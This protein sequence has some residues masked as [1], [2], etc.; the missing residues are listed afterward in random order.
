MG[1]MVSVIQSACLLGMDASTIKVEV[2][3]GLGMPGFTIVGLP[4][5]AVNESRE[6]VRAAIK[7][8][9]FDFPARKIVANLSPADVKKEGTLLDLPLALGVLLSTGNVTYTDWLS[10]SLWVGELSL[11]GS[12]N[13]VPGV[14]SIAMMAKQQGLHTV[15]VPR[16]NAEEAALVDGLQV[17]GLSHLSELPTALLNPATYHHCVDLTALYAQASHNSVKGVGVDF[18]HVKGHTV[19]KRALE[20][21]AAGG[22]NVM[23]FGPPGSGKSML[24]KAF[25]SI[26]PPMTP[27]EMLDVSRLYS[28]A[29]L[30]SGQTSLVT[31]RPFRSPHHTASPAGLTGGGS[32][33]KPGEI[34]LAHRGVLF[35]D[36]FVEFPRPV[37][38]VL[39]QPLEDGVITISRAQ[40]THTY[41]AKFT[42]LAAMNPCPCGYRGDPQ[43]SCNCSDMAV[44]RYLS[45]LS[46]PLLDRIDITLEI[47][48]LPQAD[49]LNSTP[50]MVCETS[51][52]ILSRVTA[53]RTRQQTRYQAIGLTCNSELPAAQLDVFCVLAPEA[54][55][56]LLTAAE[57]WHISGRSVH[58]L[59]KLS[60]TI[61]DLDPGH[62]NENDILA[63]H[64][65]EAL[66]YRALERIQR[67][68]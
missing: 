23:L 14:L 65:A 52:T 10:H 7:N 19:A 67:L 2:D 26:L 28:V 40:H 66:Q 55:T 32:N 22:H 49:L 44:Q 11:D 64:I 56:L 29:G 34:S 45:R 30:L 20:I 61:A 37:I 63:V 54:K 60:R 68:A 13:P 18:S 8:C 43:K 42:L 25:A 59:I 4:D 27:Q 15:V 35:L 9:Q 21:A 3:V 1:C 16:A 53:A 36:E 50:A 39:R 51:A 6:R 62:D 48:R 17:V 58:R 47:P 31:Q 12:V 33:P 38:E 5:A 46:G 41:P 57:R 24:S